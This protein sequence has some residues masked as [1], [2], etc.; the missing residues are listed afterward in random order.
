MTLFNE[1]SSTLK[2]A[3]PIEVILWSVALPGFGQFLNGKHFKG[4]LL[5]FL[6]FVI[7]VRAHLN[8]VIVSSFK[9]DVNTAIEQTDYQWL[10]FYPCVYMFSIYDAY[11]D[12]G[13]KNVPFSFLPFVSAAFLGTVGIIYSSSFKFMGIPT[14]PLWLPMFCMLAGA[15]LG[16][17]LRVLLTGKKRHVY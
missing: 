5:L 3:K 11:R 7:N 6:E 16:L 14:G 9:G 1:D 10:M 8:L 17:L 2:D 12:A 13:G 4:A 15:G